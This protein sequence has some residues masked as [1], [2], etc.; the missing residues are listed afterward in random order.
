[1]S[2]EG[3]FRRIGPGGVVLVVGPSGAGKDALITGARTKLAHDPTFVFPR[4]IITRP[5]HPAEAHI[6]MG[7]VD[8][9]NAAR[10]G[11]FALSW[12]AHGIG[13]GIP[14]AINDDVRAGRFVVANVS[15]TII[16]DAGRRYMCAPVV[17]VDCSTEIRA[18]RLAKRGR[19]RPDEILNRLRRTVDGFDRGLA[20]F[21][22]DNGGSP[23]IGI[24]HLV[25]ALRTIA[26]AA[27][28]TN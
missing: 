9:S 19:E 5:A 7:Q 1:M 6:S 21:V 15:R 20:N 23:D 8:F 16:A 14:A 26:H 12:L 25:A 22:I 27:Q 10:R 28:L 17:L 18:E 2:S 11:A 24:E 3:D 13:Y 4:R